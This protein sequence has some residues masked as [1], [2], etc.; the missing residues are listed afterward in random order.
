MSDRQIYTNPTV[1]I[2]GFTDGDGDIGLNEGDT[3]SPYEF[4]PDTINPEVSSNKFY[5][6][7]LYYYYEYIDDSWV[8]VSL[9]VPYF[10]RVPVVT[11]TGQNKALKGEIEVV[12]IL[13]P[14]RPDSIRFEVEL[15]DRALHI[16]NR[17]VTPVIYK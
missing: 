9:I 15:I 16:S 14:N 6:N 8:E 17:L 4:V 12:I 10:F 3:L 7:L 13:D 2:I 1:M 11:P 5:Y